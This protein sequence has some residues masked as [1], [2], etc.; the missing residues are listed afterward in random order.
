MNSREIILQAAL[1]LFMKKGYEKTSMS[2]IVKESNFTKGGIYHHFQN[3]SELFVETIKLLFQK[4]HDWEHSTYINC[5]N[6]KELL[7]TYFK[8]MSRFK[9][10]LIQITKQ[11][12]VEEYEFLLLMMNTITKFPKIK[13]LHQQTHKEG[14]NEIISIFKEA[15]KNGEIHTNISPH[16]LAVMINALGEGTMFYHI[17]NEKLDL[18]KIGDE[19]AE[20]VWNT[21]RKG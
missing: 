19:Y 2:D 5:K 11:E 6:L 4:F 3:K 15:K 10:F 7:Y 1:R 9:N 21:L 12:D 16:T 17:L 13:Q 18:E 8:T 20:I 14:L